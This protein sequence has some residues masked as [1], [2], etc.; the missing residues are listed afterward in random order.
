MS[1][2][3][4]REARRYVGGALMLEAVL[5]LLGHRR[6]GL[7]LAAVGG[8]CLLFFRDPERPPAEDSSCVYAAADGVVMRIEPAHEPWIERAQPLRI[9]TFLSLHNVHVTR[10]PVAGRVVES[11]RMNGGFAPA[12]LGRSEQN[13]RE[14]MAI[15][16]PAGRVV[17]VQIA[18]LVARKITSWVRVGTSVAAGQRIGLIHFGSRTDVVLPSGRVDVLVRVGDRVRAGVSPLARYR[19]EEHPACASTSHPPT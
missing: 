15:D 7:L 6:P 1:W 9:S 13:R 2:R 3:S 14:R 12:L 11:E 18:G 4:L 10:S 17:V 16:S 8:T 5:L 19:E